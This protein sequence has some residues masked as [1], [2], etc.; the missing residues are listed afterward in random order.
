[1]Y[2]IILGLTS[3]TSSS[4]TP[5]FEPLSNMQMHGWEE[6]LGTPF[7]PIAMMWFCTL[8]VYCKQGSLTPQTK[9]YFTLKLLKLSSHREPDGTGIPKHIP[10]LHVFSLLNKDLITDLSGW[11]S[12]L[13][14]PV[15]L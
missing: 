1:M 7:G 12:D 5:P 3:Y 15:G 10:T 11:L 2:P 4:F 8:N 6:E 9:P 14:L 13:G